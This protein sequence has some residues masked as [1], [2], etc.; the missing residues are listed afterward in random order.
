M[1]DS[2]YYSDKN[3]K[4]NKKGGE[5]KIK[6]SNVEPVQAIPLQVKVH[7]NF[8]RAFKAF[9][10]LVQKERILSIYKE[11]QRYEK[12]SDR[13]RRKKNEAK[14]KML[15]LEKS[16]SKPWNNYKKYNDGQMEESNDIVSEDN[17][18]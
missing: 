18:F 9:R 15:D 4:N 1:S 2:N 7:N 11:K 14:R 13:K 16:Y 8:D 17:N 5:S 3:K 10:A 6:D 12:P